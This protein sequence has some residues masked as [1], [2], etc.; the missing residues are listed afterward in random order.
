MGQYGGDN[1]EGIE[2]RGQYRGNSME[3]R[4]WRG[5]YRGD[6]IDGTVIVEKYERGVKV[7]EERKK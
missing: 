6:S 3:G 4:V 1:M 5:Y 2:W 7:R